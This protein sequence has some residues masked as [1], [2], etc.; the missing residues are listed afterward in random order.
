M[1]FFNRTFIDQCIFLSKL[2][3]FHMLTIGEW[4]SVS[5]VYCGTDCLTTVLLEGAPPCPDTVRQLHV[6]M[7]QYFLL[8]LLH[9]PYHVLVCGRAIA[10]RVCSHLLLLTRVL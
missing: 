10:L 1:Y 6:R 7:F 9:I 5:T 4:C 3:L 2:I 8:D